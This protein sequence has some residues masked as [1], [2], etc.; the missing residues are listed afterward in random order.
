L[1]ALVLSESEPNDS[2]ATANFIA[3]FGTD[4]TEDRSADVSGSREA[5]V[6]T[7]IGPFAEDEGSISLASETGLVGSGRVT[8][9]GMIGD[10]LFGSSGTGT[11][12]FD[13]FRLVAVPAG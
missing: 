10:G 12:D 8:T 5:E 9:A 6:A 13:F 7:A 3:G 2:Q 1:A 4:E 11:G